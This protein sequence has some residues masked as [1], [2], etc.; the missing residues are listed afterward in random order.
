MKRI[1]ILLAICLSFVAAQAGSFNFV[2]LTKTDKS[3][4]QISTAGLKITFNKGHMLATDANAQTTDIALN[5]LE[6]MYFTA[7]TVLRGDMNGDGKIDV[8]DVTAL[9]NG[10][11]NGNINEACDVNGDGR[12]DVSDVTT[13]INLILN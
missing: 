7:K 5:E 10:V 12:V 9:V 6:S 11:L 1:Y 8:I 13:L 2:N 4:S 3:V